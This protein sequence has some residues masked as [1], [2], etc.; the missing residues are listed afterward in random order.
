MFLG[1]GM[2][3]ASITAGRILK[4]QK[5]GKLG[6]EATLSMDTATHLGFSRVISLDF[7]LFHSLKLKTI[8]F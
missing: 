8:N 5:E 7:S 1:D 3:T 4:G 6:A 2:A